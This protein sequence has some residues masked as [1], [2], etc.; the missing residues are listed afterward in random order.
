MIAFTSRHGG[1]ENY[2]VWT[3]WADGTRL[4]QRTFDPS[5]HAD[6]AWLNG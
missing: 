3:V 4:A 1:G 6:P 5:N 2:Q